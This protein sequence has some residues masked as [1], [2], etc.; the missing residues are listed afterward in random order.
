MRIGDVVSLKKEHNQL[1]LNHGQTGNNPQTARCERI[2]DGL[3]N[4]GDYA[5]YCEVNPPPPAC[6]FGSML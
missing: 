1:R 3:R 2:L 6:L 5:N 4:Q